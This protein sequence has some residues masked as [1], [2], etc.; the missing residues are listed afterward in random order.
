[1]DVALVNGLFIRTAGPPDG[2]TLVFV[3]ALADNG[4]AFAPL[5]YTPLA[6]EFRLVAVD[7]A[8]FGASPRQDNVLTIAQHAE[9]I[10]ALARSLRATEQVGLVAHSVGSMIAVEA[11]SRLGELFG[12]LSRS[13]EI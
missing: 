7:L 6:E 4:L 9:T 11:A 1:M 3:H 12:G 8:G 5:F 10:A 13:K 2:R